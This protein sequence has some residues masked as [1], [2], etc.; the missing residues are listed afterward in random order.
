[1]PR[2]KRGRFAGEGREVGFYLSSALDNHVKAGEIIE[3][4]K[5]SQ[6][7]LRFA[8]KRIGNSD[9]TIANLK[10]G[11]EVARAADANAHQSR[12]TRFR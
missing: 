4:P 2:R 1:M 9:L 10:N 7:Q 6:S 5:L 8:G 3:L 12:L 11:D